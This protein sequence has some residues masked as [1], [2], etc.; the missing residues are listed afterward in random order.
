M[1][2]AFNHPTFGPGATNGAANFGFNVIQSGGFGLSNG[3]LSN[4]NAGNP[5]SPNGGA[6]VIELRANV[7]F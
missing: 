6:R 2:N 7:E 4:A 1:L 5:N 3:T